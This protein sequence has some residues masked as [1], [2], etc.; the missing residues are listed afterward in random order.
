VKQKRKI[1]IAT[2][3]RWN[4]ENAF[5]F[6]NT[7]ADKYETLI[8]TDKNELKYENL[9]IFSPDYVFFPHWSWM[10]PENVFRNFKCVVFHMTDLPYGRGGSP[11]QNLI[12]R[13]VYSTKIS[14]VNVTDK[15]DAG[16]IYMK[17]DLS[18]EFGTAEEIF[19]KASEIIFFKMIPFIIESSPIP[20][21]QEGEPVYFKRRKP[22]DSN[23]SRANLNSLV[24][25]YDFIRMLDAEDY[26]RAFLRIGKFKIIFS[27]VHR[28]YDKLTGR[29]EIVEEK[30][31]NTDSISTSR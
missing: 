28:K 9:K 2:I 13:K 7:Y 6:K 4:I 15:L 29:F 30:E 23:I 26:P 17:E 19:I 27:E 18:I 22:E 10:I 31:E 8:I 16:E 20:Y 24:D 21:K 25:L 12:L 11:L 14:A 1:A 3:R 5:K